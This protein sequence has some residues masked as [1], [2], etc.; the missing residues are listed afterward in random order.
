MPKYGMAPRKSKFHATG[1]VLE[2][3]K[4]G[5]AQTEVSEPQAPKGGV[6][7]GELRHEGHHVG[8]VVGNGGGGIANVF[9]AL[10]V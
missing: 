1:R 4:R 6:L 2:G 7:E 9:Q 8:F 5:A 10:S 3:G